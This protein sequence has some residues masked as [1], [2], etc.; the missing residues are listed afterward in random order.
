MVK[1]LSNTR[2][3]TFQDIVNKLFIYEIFEKYI[4]D[5]IIHDAFQVINGTN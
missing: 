5:K 3:F 2:K 4:W 1:L